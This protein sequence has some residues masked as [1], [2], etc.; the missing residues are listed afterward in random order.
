ACEIDDK[1]RKLITGADV[2]VYPMGS[3]FSSIV[4]NLLPGG[5]GRAVA[6]ADCP[7]AYV[8]NTGADPE[9]L[10]LSLARR[11]ELLL[12]TLRRDA[13]DAPAPRL[14]HFVI[15][16]EA[17]HARIKPIEL[18]QVAELGIDVLKTRLIS[19][20]SAPKIDAEL[21]ARVLVALG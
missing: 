10:G 14:L 8:P 5:V 19:E 7:K 12:E 4:A 17:A 3:F 15:V 13:P 6:E 16:D 18:K 21:L 9:Q 11:V 2:I 1:V 20:S